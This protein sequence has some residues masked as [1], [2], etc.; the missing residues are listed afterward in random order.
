MFWGFSSFES[1]KKMDDLLEELPDGK[2]EK[3]TELHHALHRGF[4]NQVL[5]EQGIPTSSILIGAAFL[6]LS[7]LLL[8][9]HFS[10]R[11]LRAEAASRNSSRF[12][13][14]QISR[15]PDL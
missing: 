8:T 15:L 11:P 4:G 12:H 2:D 9:E 10:W 14:I 1:L 6:F 7:H 13:E 5:H 3:P